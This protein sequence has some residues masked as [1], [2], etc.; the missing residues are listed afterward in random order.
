MRKSQINGLAT[1]LIMPRSIFARNAE[2]DRIGHLI[3]SL[4]MKRAIKVIGILVALL[5]V[6]AIALPF[7]LDAN[8]FRPL[9]QTR[10][11]AALS[12]EVRLG[13]LKL[14]IFS[15]SVTA[16]DLTIAD[17][18]AFSKNPFVRASSLTAGVELMPLILSRK[19]NVTGITIDQP[20]IDLV[21]NAAGVWNF[22]SIGG[23]AA[24]A[25]A[26]PASGAGPSSV[27]GPS[28]GAGP[29]LSVAMIKIANGR[30][31]LVKSARKTPL[32]LDK[33]NVEVKDFS[34]ASPF[35]FS[36]AAT[37]SGWRRH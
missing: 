19:V 7:L 15:G 4:D 36:L 10:L 29:D 8:Q 23:N 35:T 20:Q 1:I 5:L 26:S 9:L 13:D 11:T 37:F 16:S 34:V 31:T 17:D 27:P 6:A 14:S 30:I 18:P 25:A 24:Q 33:L 28:S 21:Q 12:R 32:V 22:S 2:L 3:Q